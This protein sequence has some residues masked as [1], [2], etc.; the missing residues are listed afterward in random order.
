MG[1]RSSTL[2]LFLLFC[3]FSPL[4][5][6]AQDVD[7]QTAGVDLTG[8]WDWTNVSEQTGS[9]S[10][11]MTIQ[12]D[13]SAG[14]WT[15]TWT[16][17]TTSSIWE[18]TGTV[19]G[20]SFTL[21]GHEGDVYTAQGQGTII[22]ANRL[23][24]TW[25]QSDGQ[26]GTSSAIRME[27]PDPADARIV[28]STFPLTYRIQE[29]KD[30]LKSRIESL[31]GTYQQVAE[32]LVLNERALQER[33]K[34]HRFR[35]SNVE[36]IEA[37]LSE[38][39]VAVADGIGSEDSAEMT[40]LRRFLKEAQLSEFAARLVM[41]N[42]EK[43]VQALLQRRESLAEQL[44][45]LAEPLQALDFE[46]TGMKVRADTRTVYEVGLLSPYRKL[47]QLNREIL[48][49]Q[50][51]MPELEAKRK[52]A[53]KDFEATHTAAS[54]KLLA[55]SQLIWRNAKI[56]FGAD[57]ATSAVDVAI[58][59][60]K[61]GWAGV[62]AEIAAKVY[63]SG[64]KVL[65]DPPLGDPNPGKEAVDAWFQQTTS[66][67]IYQSARAVGIERTIKETGG[68]V[69]KDYVA[70]VLSD[71][72]WA[73]ITPD[74]PPTG[75]PP[76]SSPGA[77]RRSKGMLDRLKAIAPKLKT[78]TFQNGFKE[79]RNSAVGRKLIVDAGKAF[80]GRRLKDDEMAAWRE[81]IELDTHAQLLF[82]L[83]QAAANSYWVTH[84][85]IQA[86]QLEKSDLLRGFN[87]D[88]G[89]TVKVQDTFP[90]GAALEIRLIV[91]HS[92]TPF[93]KV[94]IQ[95]F[96]SGAEATRVGPKLFVLSFDRLSDVDLEALTIEVR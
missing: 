42:K 78:E 33:I 15:W 7:A 46:L 95:V 1:V 39:R 34:D 14:T 11:V 25:T 64:I 86:K 75:T 49:L 3:L 73:D 9:F 59:G 13:V 10:G 36:S 24:G 54:A 51:L 48:E 81:Y 72:Y 16:G 94:P 29:A 20:S 40:R 61:G 35:L 56:K 28:S 93:E 27:D 66:E 45:Q 31:L 17:N 30:A 41:E 90:A 70:E 79:W 89:Q 8:Q 23:E 65:A 57:L 69:F 52:A 5:V 77:V 4:I 38:L 19:S 68:K 53:L 87:P 44:L 84:D 18:G 50:Q 85:E 12:H 47:A 76:A 6:S 82:G 62:A 92:A 22:N 58:A 55:I 21:S 26:S 83:W 32:E 88:T 96:V 43:E 37:Q 2:K 67:A 60:S 71:D 63:E 74:P 80:L 91:P